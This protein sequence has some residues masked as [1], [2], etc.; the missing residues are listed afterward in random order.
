MVVDG[1]HKENI[2]T[3]QTV[4]LLMSALLT[5]ELNTCILRTTLILKVVSDENLFFS[6]QSQI[7]ALSLKVISII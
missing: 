2:I 5:S 1:V 7:T 6:D 4:S 3:L